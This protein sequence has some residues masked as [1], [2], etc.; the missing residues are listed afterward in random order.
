MKSPILTSLTRFLVATALLG[1][2]SACGPDSPP[3]PDPSIPVVDLSED[4]FFMTP[5]M[6]I[7][8]VIHSHEGNIIV[9]ANEGTHSSKDFFAGQLSADLTGVIRKRYASIVLRD[10]AE[11]IQLTQSDNVI[12]ALYREDIS[13][14][15]KPAVI[16]YDQSLST[17]SSTSILLDNRSVIPQCIVALDDNRCAV[18]GQEIDGIINYDAAILYMVDF[19]SGEI[20]SRDIELKGTREQA[21]SL[22]YDQGSDEIIMLTLDNFTG[23]KT[24]SLYK[25]PVE[26]GEPSVL[27]IKEGLQAYADAGIIRINED[28]SLTVAATI[29]LSPNQSDYRVHIWKI[30]T[31][32][33]VQ[34]EIIGTLS[35]GWVLRGFEILDNGDYLV[36]SWGSDMYMRRMQPDGTARWTKRIASSEIILSGDVI[37]PEQD[38]FLWFGVSD[39]L[40]GDFR[41]FSILTDGEG[42]IID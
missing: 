36:S 13:G 26:T 17:L 38:R 3:E 37:A 40:S 10:R 16:Q 1:M 30:S 7:A 14:R 19:N 23:D 25:I 5:E 33:E 22:V 11:G 2:A 12:M 18:V 4:D 41:S 9:L 34:S 27:R 35:D 42:N 8:S 29:S 24:A 39:Q 28:R 20:T 6:K 32:F 15:S 31:D 21:T